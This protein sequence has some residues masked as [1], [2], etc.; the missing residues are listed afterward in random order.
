[1]WDPSPWAQQRGSFVEPVNPPTTAP[2]DAPLV[3][4]SVNQDWLPYIL[5]SLMQLA[6]PTTWITATTA[7][8][9][10]ILGR[11]ADLLACV[12]TAVPCSSQ[13]PAVGAGGAT[14]ACNIA[15]YIANMVIRRALADAIDAIN[16]NLSILNLGSNLLLVT[17]GGVNIAFYMLKAISVLYTAMVGGTLADYQDAIDDPSLMG[18]IACAIYTEIITDGAVTQANFAALV[19]NVSHVTY[20]HADVITAIVAYLNNLGSDG[21]MGLQ[22]TGVLAVY[23]CSACAGAGSVTGPA[24]MAPGEESGSVTITI[25]T[26]GTAATYE[27]LFSEVFT[28][29][30]DLVLTCDNPDL[31][32]S[33]SDLAASGVDITITAAVPVTADTAAH[34]SWLARLPG[35]S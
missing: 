5:G 35:A 15:G 16:N 19:T 25:T 14:Q 17:P 7:D 11:V 3:C 27:L 18:T 31:I 33:Y 6:Q 1:M 23:D 20:A 24:Y 26:G 9:D 34:V 21:L 2:C 32:A 13:I 10:D 4:L 30:P 12:G 28:V 29:A 22:P 8:L